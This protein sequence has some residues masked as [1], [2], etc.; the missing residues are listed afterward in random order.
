MALFFQRVVIYQPAHAKPP[1]ALRPWMESGFL[2]IRS[3]FEKVIQR[4]PLEA[5]LRD[6]KS[7]GD[8]HQDADM[9][10]L[11]TV[12]NN[13]APVDPQTPRIVSDIRATGAKDSKGLEES[14]LSLHVFLHLSQEFDQHSWELM[15]Q[16]NRLN[17]QYEA[18][19]SSFRQDETD[20]AH[21]PIQ[22]ER[23]PLEEEDIGSLVIEK[24]MAT[25]NHLF[26][27]DPADSSLLFTDS[28]SAL[29]YLLDGVQEK[30][31]VLKV[32]IT[33]AQT[34]SRERPKNQ[35]SWTDHLQEIF[36][37]ILITPWSGTLQE[38]VVEAGREIEKRINDW[39]ESTKKS[40][41]RRVLYRWYLVPDQVAPGLLNRR[42]RVDQGDKG[43]QATKVRNTLVGM[44]E[45]GPAAE[46]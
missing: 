41:D 39:R 26:Q 33:Y 22:K 29:D 2:D 7:W 37:R 35:P 44:I 36:N 46:L 3:P 25:W 1:E 14:E 24:R 15:R 23:F 38:E 42:C 13:I 12:G 5:A 16:L 21:D 31:E 4:K 18:L 17:E 45:E 19:Q 30:V 43:Y 11:K 34:E 32:N 28:R 27:K 9:A 20:Q 8:F 10:Y 6:F 40:H